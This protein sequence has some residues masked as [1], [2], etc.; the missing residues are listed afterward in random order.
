MG[1]IGC[2][3]G[4][5][6][7]INVRF[8]VLACLLYLSGGSARAQDNFPPPPG[9]TPTAD[10]VAGVDPARFPTYGVE[11]LAAGFLPD[12]FYTLAA[13]GG[14]VALG[15]AAL[16]PACGGYV[17]E[18][19]AFRLTWE[20]RS[21]RL[22][23]IF[24]PT[25]PADADP[26]LIVRAPDGSWACNRDYAPGLLRPMVEFVLPMTGDYNVWIANEIAPFIPVIGMLYVTE[27]IVTPDSLRTGETLPVA[28]LT[29]F[30]TSTGAAVTLAYEG[31]TPPADP[32]AVSVTGGGDVD[33]LAVNGDAI[34]NAAG[35]EC[36][37][38]YPAAPSFAFNLPA[39]TP[40]LRAFFVGSD[41]ATLVVRMPNGLWY[42]DDDSFETDHPTVTILGNLSSG[43][44]RMWVGSFIA[45]V[46]PSGTLTITRGNANPND[47]ARAARFIVPAVPT[48]AVTAMPF[49]QTPITLQLDAPPN[50]GSMTLERGFAPDP[51]SIAAFAG[52]NIDATA[53]GT[54]CAGYIT[55]APDVRLT[56]DGSGAVDGLLRVFFIGEGDASL[57]M[58]APDGRFLCNDDA[59]G[60]LTPAIDIADAA[61][62]VYLIWLGSIADTLTV[63]GTLY[64]T[65]DAGLTPISVGG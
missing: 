47:P 1:R 62:G 8:A 45:G 30:D 4:G 10:A 12:P 28:E 60:L 3:W 51:Q 48:P 6:G 35:A 9:V 20:G 17:E 34:R 5:A 29:G 38:F 54:D 57:V 36:P 39:G 53:L 21:T 50:A 32:Y 49:I 26:A 7:R 37:G 19:P 22:R 58:R 56:W 61:S 13:G 25:L 33:M 16:D 42:C 64:V 55:S 41:D 31:D 2:R 40:Y 43:G 15:G 59:F 27:R 63:P 23:F 14:G 65:A 18:S 24:L 46:R 11:S 44:V 52:G